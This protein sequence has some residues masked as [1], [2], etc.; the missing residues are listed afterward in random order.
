M[1]KQLARLIPNF[2]NPT[3]KKIYSFSIDIIDRLKGR[4][5]M[6]PPKRMIFVGDGEFEQIGQEFKD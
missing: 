3:L 6:I 5:S 4:D 2:P 1:K